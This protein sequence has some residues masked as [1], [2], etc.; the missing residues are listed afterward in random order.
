MRILTKTSIIDKLKGIE[1]LG[2]RLFQKEQVSNM[3]N[4]LKI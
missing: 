1:D 2:Y 4:K 3:T